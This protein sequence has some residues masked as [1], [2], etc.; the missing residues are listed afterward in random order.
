MLVSAL[1]SEPIDGLRAL[2]VELVAE[3]PAV[4]AQSVAQLSLFRR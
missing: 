2:L 3:L 4:R 1:A